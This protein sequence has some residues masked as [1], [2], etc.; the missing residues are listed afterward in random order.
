MKSIA[1][2][3]QLVPKT[4]QKGKPR[5][6]IT[7][8]FRRSGKGQNVG[9]PIAHSAFLDRIEAKRKDQIRPAA[10]STPART[11][12]LEQLC[13]LDLRLRGKRS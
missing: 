12:F 11:R 8:R 10:P 13:A 6:I 9:K 2:F 5:I 7:K 1:R 4:S 3:I